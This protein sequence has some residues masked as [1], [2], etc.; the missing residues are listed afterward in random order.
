MNWEK[1]LAYIVA[2]MNEPSSWAGLI[3]IATGVGIQLEPGQQ[4]AILTG[5]VV[6][7]GALM[8]ALPDK[9]RAEVA[10]ELKVL[11]AADPEVEPAVPTDK[12]GV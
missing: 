2:R 10:T 6:L 11:P 9:L 12:P 3:A 7:G 1:L 4:T 5:G 8:A